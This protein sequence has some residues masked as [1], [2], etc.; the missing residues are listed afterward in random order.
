M[1]NSWL[2]VKPTELISWQ[3]KI[4]LTVATRPQHTNCYILA[5]NDVE[6]VKVW[7]QQF[8]DTS[9]TQ[10]AYQKE[11]ERLLL[12]CTFEKGLALSDLKAE[13]FEEYFN[14]LQNPPN[15]WLGSKKELRAER[16][17][18][19]WWPLVAP[20]KKS[21]LLFAVRVIS[22]LMN[23]LV[24]A[25]YLKSNPIKLI[26]KYRERTIDLEDQKYKVWA[27]MLEV[28]EWDAVQEALQELPEVA[29]KEQR[30]KTRTQLLF[31]S[32]YLLGL[33]IHEVAQA[34]W[35]SFRK[36]NGNW[37]FFVKG[38]GGKLG[39]VPVN[40]QLLSMIKIYRLSLQKMPLPAED[41]LEPIFLSNRKDLMYIPLSVR[42]LFSDVKYIGKLAALKFQDPLKKKKLASLSPHWLR[43][44]SA[45]HQD[46]AGISGTIIQANHR[47]GSYSTT[48]IYLHAPD[49]LRAQSMNKIHM[50]IEPK[51]YPKEEVNCNRTKIQLS[52]VGSSLGG[53]E[54]LTRLIASIENNILID[55]KWIRVGELIEISEIVNK[56]EKI[57]NFKQ[58]LQ[59]RYEL[60]SLIEGEKLK[61]LKTAI[62]READIRLFDCKLTVQTNKI[63]N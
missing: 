5:E 58:P 49:Q 22:C 60:D 39:Q 8:K 9:T 24:E 59:I 16:Y 52:L 25:K 21:S 50:A 4:D 32:L 17:S 42:Q 47:H 31:G 1:E 18:I 14:F 41:E 46:L 23:Y 7:V 51:L 37:W 28:D 61:Y 13:H 53:I 29:P 62:L 43:H 10:R 54:S 6:A 27:R 44:L 57:K 30:F 3:P 11:A 45:S 35:G 2:V 36:L 20:L 56:Y 15:N 26:K 40:D 38:K 12:W 55:F 19:K 34:T 48:Q 63:G 33:R